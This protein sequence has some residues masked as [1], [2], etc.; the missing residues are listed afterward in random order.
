MKY[1]IWTLLLTI[2]F[3]NC[4]AQDLLPFRADTLWG[5]RDK[6]GV[7]KIKPQFQYATKFTGDI[8][9]VAKNDKL[10]AIDK[11]NHLIIPIGYEFLRPLDTAEFL[12]GYR[13]K[14]FGEYIRGVM[15]KDEKVKIPAEYNYIT[16][17][18]GAYIVTK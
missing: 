15:T 1:I 18:K 9:I 3:L 4:K 12:F 6:Q 16:K 11:N 2:T 10:G 5:F 8:A 7:V 13:A 17:Y 14:Y